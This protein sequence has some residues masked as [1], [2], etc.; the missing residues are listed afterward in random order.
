MVKIILSFLVFFTLFV[1]AE[2]QTKKRILIL[3]SYSQ[4]YKWTKSQHESFVDTLEHSITSPLE[5][6][7]EYL[8]TKRHPFTLSYQQFFLSYLQKKYEGYHP[9]A[10]YVTDDNALQFFLKNKATLFDG[11]PLIFSGVN[12]L[13]LERTVDANEY[14]GVYEKKEIVQNIE[15]VRQFS[16]QTRD[17]WFVGDNS[18][19]YQSIESDIRDQTLQYPNYT[20]HFLASTRID[21]IIKTL[22]KSPR[23]FVFLTTIGAFKDVN[24]RTLTL[25]ESIALLSKKPSI[26]LC[27]MEDAY[28]LGDVV[29]GYVTSGMKQ[30]ASA[31]RLMKR[32][33]EGESMVNIHSIVNSPN[34][35]MFDRKSL[36][37]SR[38]IL[39]AY[40]SRNAVI[41]NEDKTFFE[42]HQEGILNALFMMSVIF[43][44][45]LLLIFFIFR[46]KKVQIEKIAT[47]LKTCS[48]ELSRLNEKI[49]KSDM[50][51][52]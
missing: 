28:I 51:Y 36:V 4:E 26:I 5:F 37:Q 41:L 47:E 38:L 20:F 14:T 35:Y 40:I 3:H 6:S 15:L 16:P 23:S 9:D 45:S 24:G 21:D 13:S 52:E 27:S 10:I 49:S 31:A 43:F 11:V 50:A 7:V 44:F 42:K 29:G 17:I 12:D 48:S 18:S 30:G 46:Q 32:S 25:K 22:P 33:L 1:H 8:D 2:S 19:T 39:S 34:V